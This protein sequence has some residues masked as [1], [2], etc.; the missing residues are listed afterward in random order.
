MY[1]VIFDSERAV[2]QCWQELAETHHLEDL[3]TAYRQ[4]I[5]VNSAMC[6]K[7]FIAHFGADFP[8]DAYTAEVSKKYHDKYDHGRLPLKP[9]VRELLSCLKKNQYQIAI[10]SSTR[11][12]VVEQQIADAGLRAFFDVIVGGD[13]VEKSKPEPDI[14]LKAADLLHVLPH[15]AYVIE[16]SFNGIR[17]AFSAGTIPIM[18]PDMM[19]P[20]AEM[21]LKARYIFEDLFGVKELLG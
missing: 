7:I 5:G 2:Y 1:G 8:F 14:F 17:A 15:D 4:C 18:V 21:Q 20:D 19:E 9:G 16:D 3:D 10:A 11:T 6:R 13:M 12:S